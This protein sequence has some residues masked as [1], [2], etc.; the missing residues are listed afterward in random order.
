MCLISLSRG[1]SR[2]CH[3]KNT[4]ERDQTHSYWYI[5][6]ALRVNYSLLIMETVG[7]M[8][9]ASGD[10]SL[11]R[12]GAETGSQLVFRGYR[13]LRRRNSRSRFLSGGFGM[14]KNFWH[15][16]QVK[17]GH[18]AS[19]SQGARPRGAAPPRLVVASWLFWPNSNALWASSGP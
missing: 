18:E 14:Y 2:S 16:K 17:G 12:Q 1:T 5:P 11:F 15:R 19:T 13:G 3:L 10:G 6:S 9:M 7:M 4:R 8:K